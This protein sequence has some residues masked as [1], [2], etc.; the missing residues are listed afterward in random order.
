M[1][2]ENAI[3]LETQKSFTLPI[4]LTKQNKYFYSALWVLIGGTLYLTS[5]HN[6]IFPPQLL[7][8]SAFEKSIPFIPWT[9][10]IYSSEMFLFFSVYI[11]CKDLVNANKYLYSFLAVQITSV[12]IF[13]LWPT[14]YPRDLFPMPTDIDH[15]TAICFGNLRSVDNPNNCFPS[16]HV[17]S[18]FLSSFVY[19][20][21]QREKFPFFFGW[22]VLIAIST[23]TT[24]QH[25]IADVVSGLG[26]AIVMY[27]IFHRVVKYR[28]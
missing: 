3:S 15:L 22:A 26:L 2:D 24:K 11:V 27:Y 4:F 10:W 19:L 21:E 9:Y 17:S 7:P 28:Q 13:M 16:L 1:N 12:C 14:T 23:L 18:V 25:Y 20:D 8:M 5:N 6:P